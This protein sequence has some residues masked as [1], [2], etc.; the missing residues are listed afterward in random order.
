MTICNEWDLTDEPDDPF[1]IESI[2]PR[3]GVNPATGTSIAPPSAG[4]LAAPINGHEYVTNDADLEYACIYPLAAPKDCSTSA[5]GCE[6]DD[7][8]AGYTADDPV[9][10][11]A[12]GA[13]TKSQGY[14]RAFPGT[15]ELEVMK[16]LGNQSVVASICAKSLSNGASSAFGYNAAMTALVR[17]LGSVL[18]PP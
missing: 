9:C 12:S 15:R 6:C 5:L 13:Y 16:D 11:D 1:M 4:L 3:S 8:S 18:P 17:R 10:Q 7:V 14:A 2:K